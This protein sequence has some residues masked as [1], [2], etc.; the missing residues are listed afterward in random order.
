MLEDVKDDLV[1]QSASPNTVQGR[2][3]D[4]V[5]D[6]VKEVVKEVEAEVEAQRMKLTNII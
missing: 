6:V 4:V 1:M 3:N 2:A 5:K